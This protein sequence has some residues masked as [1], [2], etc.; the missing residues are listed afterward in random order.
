MHATDGNGSGRQAESERLDAEAVAALLAG[1]LGDAPE[2]GFAAV[3]HE[4][5]DGDGAALAALAA[6]LADAGVAPVAAQAPAARALAL[7]LRGRALRERIAADAVAVAEAVALLGPLATPALLSPLLALAQGRAQALLDAL[8]DAGALAHADPPRFARAI[9]GEALAATTPLVARDRLR[10]RAAALLAEGGRVPAA[11]A[12]LLEVAPA[13]DPGR[14]AILAAAAE[15]ERRDGSPRRAIALLER[16]LAE[17]APAPLR[18]PALIALGA[19]QVS[20]GAVAGRATLRQALNEAAD[21]AAIADAAAA[22]GWSL[23]GDARGPDAVAALE[24]A[25][26]R[27]RGATGELAIALDLQIADSGAWDV[28]L[29]QA[30][31]AALERL[32]RAAPRS[33]LAAAGRIAAEAFDA[34][35]AALPA[36]TAAELSQRALADGT[37]ADNPRGAPTALSLALML[38][39]AGRPRLGADHLAVAIAGLRTRNERALLPPAQWFR[40]ALAYLDGRLDDAERDLRTPREPAAGAPWRVRSTPLM[41]GF[42]LLCLLERDRLDEAVAV[43]DAVDLEEALQPI[44]PH[45]PF[46]YA[47]AR[48][49]LGR[50]DP[51]AALADLRLCGERLEAG[52]W[53]NPAVAPWRGVAARILIAQGE[54]GEAGALAAR[55]LALAERHGA[56]APLAQALRD[57]AATVAPSAARPLLERA[58]TVAAAA[59]G[60]IAEAHARAELGA[61]LARA[62]EGEPAREQLRA[63]LAL[64][65][66]GGAVALAREVA[67]TLRAAGGRPRRAAA[68]GLA[69]LTPAQRRVATLA[70]A[71][72]TNREIAE[73]LVVTPKTVESHLRETFRKLEIGSR[74]QLPEALRAAAFR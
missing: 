32:E 58:V 49:R 66:A 1:A 19:T 14:A 34:T 2:E 54:A 38:G 31:A 60:A 59:P 63:A 18:G 3:C 15:Q 45:A 39:Y 51:H 9:D 11:G 56:P 29:R 74:A 72:H 43:L 65:R 71:G 6:A 25:R 67:A 61:L 40:G 36:A 46:L 17:P 33:P 42:L 47:R 73:R 48:L 55:E 23:A 44:T 22:L 30:R 12:L 52:G 69:V 37:L 21:P 53:H 28:E 26:E 7:A 13:G 4:L 20:L 57:R 16:L 50:G 41:T 8:V 62:G 27:V 70:A 64:A 24:Q 5:T 10:A 35:A 68:A